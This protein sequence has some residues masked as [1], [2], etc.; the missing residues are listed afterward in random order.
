MT[1]EG[2]RVAERF[3]KNQWLAGGLVNH[4]IGPSPFF[5]NA[6]SKKLAPAACRKYRF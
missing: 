3:E 4:N 5:V 1:I 2:R 6:D